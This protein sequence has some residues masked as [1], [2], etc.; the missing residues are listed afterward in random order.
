MKGTKGLIDMTTLDLTKQPPRPPQFKLGGYVHLAR[1][2]DKCRAML[3]NKIGEYHYD[4][5]VDKMLFTFKNISADELKKVVESK[6]TDEQIVEWINSVGDKKTQA[7]IDAWSKE[8][9]ER[10]PYN[11]PDGKE[12]FVN[13]CKPLN[14]DPAN[15]TLFDYLNADDKATFNIK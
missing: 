7:Q 2:I 5:P 1:A 8:M 4:C 6:K 13:V 14:I 12:W 10:S 3:V 15:S 11:R 9:I